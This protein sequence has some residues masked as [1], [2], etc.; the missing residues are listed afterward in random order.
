MNRIVA[1]IAVITLLIAGCGVDRESEDVLAADVDTSDATDASEDDSGES[2]DGD[3]VVVPTP[4]TEAFSP[5]TTGAPDDVALS[6][7]FGDST[8]EI[9]H[10]ELNALVVPT[11]EN[12]TFVNLVFQGAPPPDFTLTVL[13]ENLFSQAVQA[14]LASKGG[15]VSDADI[16]ASEAGLIAQVE[17]LL[18][19]TTDPAAEAKALYDSTPYLPFLVQYQASQD[20]LT[21]LL[22]ETAD[23][24][25]GIPCVR[26]ILMDTADEAQAALSRL[27]AGEDFGELAV[28]LSTGP[29]GPNGGELGC[30]PSSQYV[31]P[32]AEAV[33][34]AEIGEFVGPVE[35]EFGFHVLVVDR[36]EVDGRAIAT[37]LLQERVSGATVTIDEKLGV[38]DADRLAITPAGS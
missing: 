27:D 17:G 9:T 30:S 26:H 12:V 35:T 1:V 29:S 36:T 10:G 6:V 37:E 20:A 5:P 16:A 34:G 2:D 15:S 19:S 22:A 13:T 11:Q 18:T 3:G 7:D 31:L 38:W 4:T 8:W 33:D 23:P 28:E 21:A 25:D 32:F 24:A 14:E